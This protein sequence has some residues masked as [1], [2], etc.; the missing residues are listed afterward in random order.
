M[1]D[2]FYI[3]LSD[4]IFQSEEL[5]V[6]L[7]EW[8]KD[9]QPK[10]INELAGMYLSRRLEVETGFLPYDRRVSYSVGDR[11]VVRLVGHT[12]PQPA[13]VTKVS[14]KTFFDPDGFAG[15]MITVHLLT[16]AAFLCGRE[17]TRF[18]A[19]YQGEEKAGPAV[20]ALQIITEQDESEAIPKILLTIANDSRLV[21]FCQH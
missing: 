16:Q 21:N 15:D 9:P 2:N 7:N 8:L 4:C 6:L 19:N 13:D 1:E 12:E 10:T 20:V 18:I 3:N 11:I 14:K 17:T 5:D